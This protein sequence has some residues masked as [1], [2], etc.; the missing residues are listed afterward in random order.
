M[1]LAD[2]RSQK[3][4]AAAAVVEGSM[5][6]IGSGCGTCGGCGRRDSVKY[7]HV[8]VMGRTK[9]MYD[10]SPGTILEK[11]KI[12]LDFWTSKCVSGVFL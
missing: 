3:D 2:I 8:C 1:I 9:N 11:K 6:Q 7:R 10:V 4:S 12:L 5:G